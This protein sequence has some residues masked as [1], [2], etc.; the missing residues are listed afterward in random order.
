MIVRFWRG[1]TSEEHADAYVD[2]LHATGFRNYRATPGNRGVL[3]LRRIRNGRAEFLL[4]TLWDSMDAV[5]R[6]AGDE[7]EKAVF[8]PED[9]AFLVERDP[10]V[11]HFE[12][13]FAGGDVA[14]G[15]PRSE[16]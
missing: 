3:G 4:V 10:H 16:S 1:A 2:V 13:V 15:L 7:P 6:F 14:S 5:R 11:D 8:Y 9:D 12:V